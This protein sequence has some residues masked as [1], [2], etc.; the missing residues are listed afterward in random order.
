MLKI[1]N[2][3]YIF[4]FLAFIFLLIYAAMQ[5]INHRGAKRIDW[6][7]SYVKERQAYIDAGE[8]KEGGFDIVD[9]YMVPAALGYLSNEDIRDLLANHCIE[10]TSKCAQINL[11][12][13]SMF[14][15]KDHKSIERSIEESEKAIGFAENFY[16]SDPRYD[17]FPLYL[18][19]DLL[20]LFKMRSLGYQNEVCESCGVE[21]SS[22]EPFS[23]LEVFNPRGGGELEALWL[24]IVAEMYS[25]N[26]EFSVPIY[27][28]TYIV[29]Q[30]YGEI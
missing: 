26:G 12:L 13:A 9:K 30:D 18:T 24:A 6:A 27:V 5:I 2:L 3:L 17:R 20:M 21:M 23:G 10:N 1:R 15:S 28:Y 25:V 16:L 22:V 4:I 7:V 19:K 14:L 11:V 8:F 29:D